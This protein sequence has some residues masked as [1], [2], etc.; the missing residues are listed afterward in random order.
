MPIITE[1]IPFIPDRDVRG[2]RI[3]AKR[4]LSESARMVERLRGLS[5]GRC[6]TLL[7][8][9]DDPKD[10]ARKRVHWSNAAKRAGMTII[11]RTI[12]TDAGDRAIRIW[13]KS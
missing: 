11:T 9:T 13:R 8:D 6:I 10:L 5:A 2:Q 7:P 1:D 12:Y 3:P 4:S